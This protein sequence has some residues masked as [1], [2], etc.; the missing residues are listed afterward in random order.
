[1]LKRNWRREAGRLALDLTIPP[2]TTATVF[3]PTQTADEVRESGVAA[4][5]SP[6]VQFLRLE[7]GS[8]I[9]EVASGRYEFA[10]LLR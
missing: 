5:K 3:L 7:N 4:A 2:N 1:L 6:G 8:A 10:T 9:F